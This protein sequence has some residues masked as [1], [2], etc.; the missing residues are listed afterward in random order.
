MDE[1]T[2]Q[3]IFEPFF[4]TKPPGKGTGLGL[5]T[6]YGITVQSGGHVRVYS[7]PG[8]GTRFEIWLPRDTDAPIADS[9]LPTDAFDETSLADAPGL[10]GEDR[11]T[12]LVAEDEDPVRQILVTSLSRAGYQVLEAPD[13]VTAL[14]TAREHPGPIHL[15]VTDVVMP[16]MRGPELAERI[17]R[18]RRG[19]RVLFISGYT[20]QANLD[21]PE[22]TEA[23]F[24]AKPFTPEELRAAVRKVLDAGAGIHPA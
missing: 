10:P 21:G 12:V 13:G 18:A 1:E 2:R 24:L 4:T 9:S 23:A 8:K 15:L 6:V 17:V 20:E 16:G 5:S 14:A 11:E 7:W 22:G 19:L 3:R